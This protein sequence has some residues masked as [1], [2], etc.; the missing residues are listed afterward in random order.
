MK[1]TFC[2]CINLTVIFFW[3][4]YSVINPGFLTCLMRWVPNKHHADDTERVMTTIID[5]WLSAKKMFMGYQFDFSEMISN[6]E[7]VKRLLS[8]MWIWEFFNNHLE[9]ADCVDI[10]QETLVC[11]LYHIVE[12]CFWPWDRN[13]DRIC[14]SSKQR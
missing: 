1:W 7:F 3:L 8:I 6:K 2:V 14:D 9:I 12:W 4:T 13:N 11:W 5:Y 10:C